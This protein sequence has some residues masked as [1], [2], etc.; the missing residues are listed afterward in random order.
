MNGRSTFIFTPVEEHGLN[1]F[2]LRTVRTLASRRELVRPL[3][4][5]SNSATR[6]GRLKESGGKHMVSE[7]EDQSNITVGGKGWG[8]ERGR[9]RRRRGK[10]K[11]ERGKTKN[12]KGLGNNNHTEYEE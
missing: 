2:Q 3:V 7:D 9:R 10:R 4:Y 1:M 5:S 6:N 8:V 12:E 11:E